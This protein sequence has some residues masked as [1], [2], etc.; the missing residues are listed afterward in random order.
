MKIATFNINNVRHRLPNL[1]DWLREANPDVVCL[2]ELKAAD[3]E[4]PADA[5]K[6]A[7]Y[8]AIWRGQ[9]TWNGV[10]ILSRWKPIKTLSELPGDPTDTQS[11]YIEAAVNGIV[12]ASLYAPNGNPQPGPKFEYKLAWLRRLSTYAAELLAAR[13]PV[14]LAGDYNV[15]PTDYDIYPSKSWDKDALVQPA[16]R[17]AFAALTKQGWVDAVRTLY[18][19][20]P[21]YT[22]WHYLR[23]RWQ[24]NAGLRIDHLLLSP[25][26]AELL[27]AAGVD[28]AVRGEPGASDHAPVWIELS[29][30]NGARRRQRTARKSSSLSQDS[31]EAPSKPARPP[32]S[33]P[34]L[35]ID[36]DSFAHRA[37][38]ALPK[39]IR[40]KDGKGA[41]AIVGFANQLLRLYEA[42]N[43]RAVIVGW[44]TLE[45]PTERHERFP[46]YQSGREFDDA[47]VDQ[48][49]FLPEFVA[50]CGF[51]NA[52]GPGYEA[53][54]F[55]AAA[56][57]AEERRRGNAIVASGDRDTF[58]LASDH[59][60]ILYPVRAGEMARIGPAEVKERYGVQPEQV[61][62]F[63][64]LRG[65]PS[66]KLPGAR[67][68]GPKGAADLLKRH[69]TLDG[70]LAAGLFPNQADDLRL[71]RSIAT[72]NRK[73][74]LPSLAT[75]KPT[76]TRAADLARAWGLNQL[77]ERLIKL[78]TGNQAG[79]PPTR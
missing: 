31:D 21:M 48:L 55:L 4:F 64:A 73:A 23:N 18:P 56:V 49:D 19:T 6:E 15:V 63:I 14:V 74:P 8:E 65:D 59:T 1:L 37:Y 61:P 41:G 38:H 69:G 16:S 77:A 67:G 3:A 51:K 46:A 7:G 28:R 39:T 52:K 72:M 35:V 24:R 53:D 66:D 9:K 76:W 58:Q 40:R 79:V 26:A 36:G 33:R 30:Q 27:K 34:L 44:D 17:A 75:Q 5:I 10:A 54:D 42:E 62:D 45:A 13:V 25:A 68:V 12:V 2:Q 70:I 43:P 60:T 29:D 50:A 57:A 11:R 20:E 32:S 71:F 22:F 78:P 47:L